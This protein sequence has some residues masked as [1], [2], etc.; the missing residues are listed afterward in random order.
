MVQSI[1]GILL[2]VGTLGV[3]ASVEELNTAC[4][5]DA[6]ELIDRRFVSEL[7]DPA[8]APR[9]TELLLPVEV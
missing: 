8:M 4:N 7:E 2:A 1:G 3:F 9:L 6:A 5:I